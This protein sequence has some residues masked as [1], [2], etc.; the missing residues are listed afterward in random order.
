M[1]MRSALPLIAGDSS[2]ATTAINDRGQAVGISGSCDQAVG[3]H[4][5]ARGPVIAVAS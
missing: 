5:S 2:G 4:R 1:S 3:R